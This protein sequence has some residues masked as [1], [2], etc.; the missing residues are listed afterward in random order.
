MERKKHKSPIT[1]GYYDEK[2]FL[3]GKTL[4][5]GGYKFQLLK[6]DEYTEKYMEDNPEL[7]PEASIQS[8]LRK[9]KKGQSAYSSLQEYVIALIKN[10]DKN[11]DGV[12]SFKEFCDGLKAM[13]IFV[14]NH[15]EHTLMRRFDHNQD[16]VISMEEFYNTLAAVYDVI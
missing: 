16:G 2:D 1:Q 7:F 3:L 11:G 6:A 15:E 4:F 14:S 9:I 8:I 12:I 5:L 13:H 10:L